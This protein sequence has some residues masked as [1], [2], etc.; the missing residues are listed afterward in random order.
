MTRALAEW[1]KGGAQPSPKAPGLL[2]RA[3]AYTSQVIRA[4]LDQKGGMLSSGSL[5]G[6][7]GPNMGMML[8]PGYMSAMINRPFYG[9]AD[10]SLAADLSRAGSGDKTKRCHIGSHA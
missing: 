2:V 8:Q 3:K 6:D 4:D 10:M 5:F 7:T 1:G 9:D